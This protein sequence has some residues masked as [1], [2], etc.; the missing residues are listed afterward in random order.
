MNFKCLQCNYETK[1]KCNYNKH[2][3]TKKHINTITSTIQEI[4][5]SATYHCTKCE[6]IIEDT[7][8]LEYN[9]LHYHKKCL[10]N[11]FNSMEQ[12]NSQ[13]KIDYTEHSQAYGKLVLCLHETILKSSTRHIDAIERLETDHKIKINMVKCEMLEKMAQLLMKKK[14]L[15][16]NEI[17]Y[18][19]KLAN[20]NLDNIKHVLSLHK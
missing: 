19:Y 20:N 12:E 4:E 3:A 6:L 15:E 11:Q 14:E 9:D 5:P 10:F 18:K 16:N 13:L 17:L 2:L 7:D 8:T 1:I